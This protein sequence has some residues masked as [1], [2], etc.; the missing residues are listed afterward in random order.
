MKHFSCLFL[1]ALLGFGS[2]LTTISQECPQLSLTANVRPNPRRGIVAGKGMARIT[3]TLRSKDPVDNVEFQLS[4][5]DG[6]SVEQTA[7]RPSSKPYTPPQIVEDADGVTAI[8]WQGL[9]FTKRKGG[10]RRFRVKVKA[11]Q[12]A[13][14]TLVVNALAYLMNATDISCRTPLANPAIIKVRYLK[15][16]KDATCAPTPAPTVNP[17]QPFVLLGEGLRFSQ[18]ERLAPFEDR[19]LSQHTGIGSASNGFPNTDTYSIAYSRTD[20]Y[21]YP[22]TFN[23]SNGSPNAETYSIAYSRTDSY[24]YPSTL[25]DF[26]GSPNADTYSIAY[27]RTDSYPYPSTLNDFN[28]SPNADTYSI[29]YSRTDLYPYPSTFNDSNGSPNAD[30][31]SIAFSRTDSYPYPSTFNDSNGS[32]NADTYSIAYS[33]THSYPY[34][35]TFL[36]YELRRNQY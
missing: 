28:G 31:Y 5:P 30:T 33:S 1:F 34:P 27:S 25:N 8:S 10:K 4:L 3:V 22:S 18:G 29:A 14:E 2:I 9:A 12:C 13:P 32:P 23:D 7:M 19:R 35:S 16:N 6:L 17:T 24:P 26:N 11:D 20:S 36:G 15:R 21:P